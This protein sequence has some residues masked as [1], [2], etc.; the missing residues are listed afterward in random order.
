[1]LY[2]PLRDFEAMPAELFARNM[3]RAER[4]FDVMEQLGAD[5]VLVCSNVQ[6]IAINDPARAA[7]A[8]RQMM[9]KTSQ[10]PPA[11][12]GIRST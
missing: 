5:T 1:M 3:A 6:D 9:T 10:M 2:Q 4:K 12:T 8:L 7:A 11:W